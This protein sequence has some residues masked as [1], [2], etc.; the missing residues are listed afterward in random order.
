MKYA[1]GANL[2]HH[3]GDVATKGDV[4]GSQTWLIEALHTCLIIYF[5]PEEKTETNRP[6]KSDDLSLK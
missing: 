2:S 4:E 5:L 6:P 3:K 1:I